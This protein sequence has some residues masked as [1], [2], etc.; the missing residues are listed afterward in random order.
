MVPTHRHSRILEII[1]QP[2]KLI[3]FRIPDP[4]PRLLVHKHKN[5]THTAVPVNTPLS[6]NSLLI[7]V[8]KKPQ[9]GWDSQPYIRVVISHCQPRTVPLG[10]LKR[11]PAICDVYICRLDPI[12]L[13][14]LT[15]LLVEMI[16]L[17]HILPEPGHLEE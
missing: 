10:I 13:E 4:Q 5:S 8:Q 15:L 12:G 9:Q 1:V 16:G 11:P 3:Q 6:T 14:L 2:L 17:C 7:V